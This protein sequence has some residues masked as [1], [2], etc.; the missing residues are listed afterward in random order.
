MGLE[1]Q[2]LSFWQ[3]YTGLCGPWSS[4]SNFLKFPSGESHE[5]TQFRSDDVPAPVSDSTS[6]FN[7]KAENHD[8]A[9]CLL[10]TIPKKRRVVETQ[11]PEPI[12]AVG[13]IRHM[14]LGNVS[15]VA[16]MCLTSEITLFRHSPIPI[17]RSKIAGAA[18]HQGRWERASVFLV[19]RETSRFRLSDT[20]FMFQSVRVAEESSGSRGSMTL[21]GANRLVLR[22]VPSH[23]S[24]L[25]PTDRF[26][27]ASSVDP[28][29]T[30]SVPLSSSLRVLLLRRSSSC[31]FFT[32]MFEKWACPGP[33]LLFF[34][35]A[36]DWCSLAFRAKQTLSQTTHTTAVGTWATPCYLIPCSLGTSSLRS[37]VFLTNHMF[38]LPS[39]S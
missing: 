21:P 12:F 39:C 34:L 11:K 25:S 8:Q 1:V 16:H 9:R 23:Q 28:L 3:I 38:L 2:L 29:P 20:W 31:F 10:P 24:S 14:W 18:G 17:Q 30:I 19:G 15:L 33:S 22:A 13:S 27:S 32:K 35:L 6:Y 4:N 37:Y 7:S 26:L 5:T 36:P